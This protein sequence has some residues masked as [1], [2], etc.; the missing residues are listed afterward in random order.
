MYPFAWPGG[1]EAFLSVVN[2]F[3]TNCSLLVR[4][5]STAALGVNFTRTIPYRELE[6]MNHW[7]MVNNLDDMYRTENVT[8]LAVEIGIDL[9]G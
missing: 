6:S 9:T 8:H 3:P 7:N 4:R 2:A 5:Q 1:R